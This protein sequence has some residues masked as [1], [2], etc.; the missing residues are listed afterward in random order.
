MN[1]PETLTAALPFMLKY[2]GQTVV[3]KYGGNAMTDETIK[4]SVLSDILL[5]KTM[6]I[7]VVLVHGGGPAI[8]EML[9]KYDMPSKFIGG[10]RYTDK[11]TAELALAAL[12]GMV[13]K[14]LV[15][16]IQ[17]LGGDAIGISGIDGRM[18]EVE[19]LSEELGYVG[20]I[21]KINTEIIERIAKT[22]AIPV[23]AT[24]GVDAAGEIY[25]VNADTAASRIAGELQAERFILLSD[26]RGLYADY[27]DESSFLVETSLSTIEQ[28]IAAGKISGGMIPKLEAIQYA[29]QNGLSEAVLLDG[30]MQHSLILELFTTEG[31]GTLIKKDDLDLAKFDRLTK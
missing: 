16:D 17:R 9:E 11:A 19:Q 5:L 14:S 30:R 3:I 7:N 2:Q 22:S 26:V 29:M 27:P 13:N 12:S 20:K 6:G 4:Q 28:L 25:N 23:I 31:F 15:R 8:S 18:I 21:T 24:A 10:L 1:M